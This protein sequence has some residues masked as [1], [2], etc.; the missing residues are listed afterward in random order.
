MEDRLAAARKHY[1]ASAQVLASRRDTTKEKIN[2]VIKESMKVKSHKDI[3]ED[4]LRT[5]SAA[6]V[7]ESYSEEA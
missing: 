4:D 7:A 1:W 3:S 6:M 2:E 5:I